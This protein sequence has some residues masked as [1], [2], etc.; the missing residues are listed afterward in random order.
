MK[1][2]DWLEATS[3]RHGLGLTEKEKRRR[4]EERDRV[5]AKAGTSISTLR[6]AVC[7][8][9]KGRGK[10]GDSLLYRLAEATK[11]EKNKIRVRDERPEP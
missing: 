2:R 9:A 4:D 7:K 5:L 11:E 8:Q 3:T 1:V 10:I 6:V